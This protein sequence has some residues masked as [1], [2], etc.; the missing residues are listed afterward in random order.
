MQKK[1]NENRTTAGF[2]STLENYEMKKYIE[3]ACPDE[4][5]N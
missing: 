2:S 3:K 1:N 5:Y 4:F